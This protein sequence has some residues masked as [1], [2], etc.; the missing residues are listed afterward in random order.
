MFDALSFEEWLREFVQEEVA[1]AV[2]SELVDQFI[3]D[4]MHALILSECRKA[5]KDAVSQISIEEGARISKK[6]AEHSERVVEASMDARV[7]KTISEAML[8]KQF[9][10]AVHIEVEGRMASAAAR[11]EAHVLKRLR[12]HLPE[13][14]G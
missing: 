13:E 6:L 14:N 7:Q 10:Q 8:D 3:S 4:E 1:K 12:A 11:M 5:V 2:R 9:R